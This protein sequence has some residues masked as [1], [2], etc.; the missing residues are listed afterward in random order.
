MKNTF[1]F[2][3]PIAS[4]FGILFS[5]CVHVEKGLNWYSTTCGV[6]DLF[7]FDKRSQWQVTLDGEGFYYAYF[8]RRI[9]SDKLEITL[10]TISTPQKWDDWLQWGCKG[11]SSRVTYLI[12]RQTGLVLSQFDHH[13]NQF[14]NIDRQPV[15]LH[16]TG[17]S[18]AHG[19]GIYCPGRI[20]K[21]TDII[22]PLLWTG[23]TS[24]KVELNT[25]ECPATFGLSIFSDKARSAAYLAGMRQAD[26]LVKLGPWDYDHDVFSSFDKL[27]SAILDRYLPGDRVKLEYLRHL[28]PGSYEL[29][30]TS[31]TLPHRPIQEHPLAQ[32]L[33]EFDK[34]QFA[35][36]Q[37]PYETLLNGLAQQNAKLNDNQDLLSRLSQTHQISDPYRLAPFYT[38]HRHPFMMGQMA[39]FCQADIPSGKNL[40]DLISHFKILENIFLIK[41]PEIDSDLFPKF[42]DDDLELHLNYIEKVLQLA[43]TYNAQ[44]FHRFS[45]DERMFMIRQMP[46]LMQTFVDVT[47]LDYDP[48]VERQEGNIKLL[49]MAEKIDMSA[50]VLQGKCLS[51]L[52]GNE[53]LISI[54]SAM[55]RH[56]QEHPEQLV[57][58]TDYGKIIL[59]GSENNRYYK[60]H[61]AAVIVDLGGDDY[62]AN[63]TG[64][65]YG[66]LR[67]SAILIDFEG[68]DR[69]ENWKS[70]RQGAGI[71][72][73]G[74]LVDVSGNDH[75]VGIRHAQGVG[76]L[77]IG[78]LWDHDGN[79]RYSAI[80]T[81]QAVGHFGAGFLL[82]NQG[83]N[84][85]INGRIGQG[86]GFTFGVG[87]LYS[88][89][90]G[91]TDTYI[92]KGQQA[93]SY[94]D[95]GSFE[96]W[97]QGVG[98]GFRPF[99]SG[100]IGILLDEGGDDIYEAG[101]FSQGGGYFYGMGILND[102]GNGNDSYLGT[103]YNMGFSAH[104]ATGIFIDEA[105]NDTYKT[106][107]QVA[108][109]IAWDEASS[110]FIDRSGNDIYDAPGFAL[111]AAAM[112]GFS[113]FIDA[114][115][116]DQ[117]V[118]D[119]IP[120]KTYGNR[121]HG[122]TSLAYF[123]DLGKES[124]TY[125]RDRKNGEVSVSG[126]NAFFI[127]ALTLDSIIQE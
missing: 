68:N 50:I 87:L 24:K 76:F 70:H 123:L 3:I 34:E 110:L 71:L 9:L 53:F 126:D 93:S 125:N 101:T 56:F 58:H 36:I 19:D 12:E 11:A 120:A 52:L 10:A 118:G 39:E 119:S 73:V 65:S 17:H 28:E 1:K 109:S 6:D 111:G 5:S 124:D 23:F 31:V 78:V 90:S 29:I 62:Y 98:I 85:F 74:M 95:D 38:A 96:G 43:Q 114:E 86:V 20:P 81:S 35:E 104:Q 33:I 46:H 107:H 49:E 127:D 84:T 92:N 103:R 60:R 47:M 18:S 14:I 54:K 16:K 115:G 44:A 51:K 91:G 41:A 117:Y 63:N 22:Q 69:Y 15:T 2:A 122:G 64:S 83:N 72:G 80:D 40:L 59:S 97:G 25:S 94:G 112:N 106:T 102:R 79:D 75:Y 116:S 89:D 82:D 113:I 77:G 37:N 55:K 88:A 57:R 45:S 105:G 4:F 8:A 27:G 13:T 21:Y 121:Y 7:R 67:P 30:K 26:I 61:D 100:G 42:A 108:M 66:E 32:T 48:R 99:T